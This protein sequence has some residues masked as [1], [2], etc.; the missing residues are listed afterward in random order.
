MIF[1]GF[2]IFM[3]G[4]DPRD[5]HF[6]TSRI[7][8]ICGDNH[9]TTSCLN[10]N[11]AYGVQPPPLGDYAFNLAELA[12]LHVRPRDLQRLHVQRGLLRADGEG[13]QPVGA[14]TGREHHVA[15][16]RTSTATGRSPTSC[17]R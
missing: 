8:G 13:D 12:G 4:I 6:I 10:Q 9:C 17:G 15:E 11:M 2:D 1:R 14:G 5:A 7:C 3:K 16:R